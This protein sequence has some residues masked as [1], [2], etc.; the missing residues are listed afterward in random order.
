MSR[1]GPE[2]W[3]HLADLSSMTSYPVFS[4]VYQN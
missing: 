4:S 3:T 1:G 2:L